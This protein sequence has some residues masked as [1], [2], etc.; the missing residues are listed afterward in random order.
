MNSKGDN[1]EE[2]VPAKSG[3]YLVALKNGCVTDLDYSYGDGWWSDNVLA[4]GKLPSVEDILD[5][6]D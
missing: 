5:E 3:R 6:L 1:N 4:W 2:C